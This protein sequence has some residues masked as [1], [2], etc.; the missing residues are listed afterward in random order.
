MNKVPLVP[1]E[2]KAMPSAF[3][4]LYTSESH[5]NTF[6]RLSEQEFEGNDGWGYEPLKPINFETVKEAREL[7]KELNGKYDIQTVEYHPAI[8]ES[9]E[10]KLGK[11]ALIAS[12]FIRGEVFTDGAVEERKVPSYATEAGKQLVNNLTKY[13][14]DKNA[15]KEPFL[16][17]IFRLSQYTFTDGKFVLHDVDPMIVDAKK[18]PLG[19]TLEMRFSML[20]DMAKQFLPDEEFRNWLSDARKVIY[21]PKKVA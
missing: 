10:N 1:N 2:F 16:Y 6:V 5:P 7:F 21:A 12:N 19:V 8:F 13:L 3:S 14:L 4:E 9:T 20:T 18:D 17:D 15:S 11:G